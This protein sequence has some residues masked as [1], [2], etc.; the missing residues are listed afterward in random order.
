ML[1]YV[2][3]GEIFVEVPPKKALCIFH[4][5]REGMTA[6]VLREKEGAQLK[7]AFEHLF[8][9]I[10]EEIQKDWF[11]LKLV[12][13][14]NDLYPVFREQFEEEMSQT[15]DTNEPLFAFQF[16]FLKQLNEEELLSSKCVFL[17]RRFKKKK[18]AIKFQQIKGEAI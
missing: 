10:P 1:Y 5:E 4:D 13:P 7:W 6:F 17:L 15:L 14:V 3:R 12:P 18:C 11:S 9:N 8:F 2:G 16:S